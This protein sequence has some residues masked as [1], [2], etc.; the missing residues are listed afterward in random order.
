MDAS[1]LVE[2]REV[3]DDGAQRP[4]EHLSVR[5][6]HGV[7]KAPLD[8]YAGELESS[9]SGEAL[10]VEPAFSMWG[11]PT[12]LGALLLVGDGLA[13]EASGHGELRR[14]STPFLSRQEP[15]KNHCNQIE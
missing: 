12:L 14:K 13:L 11:A 10:G 5:R 2:G 8:V 1:G 9:P 6:R 3:G 15:P 7:V 4:L